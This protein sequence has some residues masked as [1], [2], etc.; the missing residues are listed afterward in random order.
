MVTHM[1]KS[2]FL[3]IVNS[4]KGVSWLDIEALGYDHWFLACGETGRMWIVKNRSDNHHG[5][6]VVPKEDLVPV[7]EGGE[8]QGL[9]DGIHVA[10]ER[11]G[12][13]MT[14]PPDAEEI[15]IDEDE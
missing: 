8:F 9:G 10:R 14:P 13:K 6:W 11:T 15:I 12:R 7:Y 2:M 3:K 4:L 5:N 1:P